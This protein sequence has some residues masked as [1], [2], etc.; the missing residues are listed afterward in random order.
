[1]QLLMRRQGR[2]EKSQMYCDAHSAFNENDEGE[3]WWRMQE[4]RE[5]GGGADETYP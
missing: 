1:M 3:G 5:N 2:T 4:S